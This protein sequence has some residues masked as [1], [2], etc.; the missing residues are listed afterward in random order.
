MAKAAVTTFVLIFIP[1]IL[2]ARFAVNT[3]L[4][5]YVAMYSPSPQKDMGENQSE[6][7]TER[8]RERNTVFLRV[9][10]VDATRA[11]SS[12]SSTPYRIFI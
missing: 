12:I 3:A 11:S 4:G 5:Y 8:K 2:V 10:F 1:A 9:S 6:R 7:G